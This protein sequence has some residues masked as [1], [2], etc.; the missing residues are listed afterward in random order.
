MNMCHHQVPPEQNTSKQSVAFFDDR[1]SG[2]VQ[3]H[4]GAAGK[5]KA[6]LSRPI[7]LDFGGGHRRRGV[8]GA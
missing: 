3:F 4:G 6:G 1:G 5:A 7:D 8:R 2:S